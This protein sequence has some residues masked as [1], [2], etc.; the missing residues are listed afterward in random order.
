MS[1]KNRRGPLLAIGGALTSLAVCAG[2][3]VLAPAA[4]GAL[5]RATSSTTLAVD[6]AQTAPAH[7]HHRQPP[8]VYPTGT[9]M[10]QPTDRPTGKPTMTPTATPPTTTPGM[11]AP[12]PASK[13]CI[14]LAP[15]NPLTAQ[16]LA[17][18]YQLTGPAGCTMA[19]AAAVGAFVQATIAE[20]GGQLEVYD[21]LVV[22]A[23]T[24][25]AAAPPVPNIP[26]GSV[27]T[28]DTG[29]NGNVLTIAGAG[30]RYFTQGLPGSP[31]GQVSFANGPAFFAA[32]ANDVVQPLSLA[33]AADNMP[34]PTTRDFSLVDQDQSDNVTTSYRVTASGQT[35][36]ASQGTGGTLVNNGS[37]N[38]LLTH[39]VDPALGCTPVTAPD[40]SN[41][42]M[43]GSQALDELQAMKD[44]QMPVAL[45]PPNDPMTTVGADADITAGQLPSARNLSVAKTDLYRAQVG[46]PP[47]TGS[48]VTTAGQYCTDL[49]A[50]GARVMADAALE[51][52]KPDP[53]GGNDLAGFMKARYANSLILL[54]CALFAP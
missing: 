50:A 40:L 16:G 6:T 23:G 5:G 10:D 31:F 19:N 12:P 27:V 29:F 44:Q 28:I 13:N 53:N 39:F 1:N 36:E 11:M 38:L 32:A 41:G 22:T 26:A 33:M 35:E 24:Q 52:G 8:R 47:L 2:A 18:P 17:T 25:P 15:A 37:D 54:N 45:V 3:M 48:P 49:K 42:G 20:P 30:G 43:S 7:H 34:C 9:P 14:L 46:Q 51:A 4:G 21:P